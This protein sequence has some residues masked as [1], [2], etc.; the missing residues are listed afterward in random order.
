MHA[1]FAFA[2]QDS[3][4]NDQDPLRSKSSLAGLLHKGKTK[5]IW[6]DPTLFGKY[7]GWLQGIL[8]LIN[9]HML[10]KTFSSWSLIGLKTTKL[11]RMSIFS[12]VKCNLQIEIYYVK[13]WCMLSSH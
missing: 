3:M 5:H 1:N 4:S 8:D 7:T 13:Q 10:V 12:V 9:W 2:L 6:V 11:R